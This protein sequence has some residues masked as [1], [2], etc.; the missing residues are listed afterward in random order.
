MKKTINSLDIN[1]KKKYIVIGF[2]DGIYFALEFARQNPK[3]IIE[4]ISLDGSWVSVKMC[5]NRLLNWKKR[6]NKHQ[7]IQSQ[8]HLDNI[9]KN[10][11]EKKEMSFIKL[12]MNHK[13]KEH[14]EKCI[15]YKYENIIKKHKFTLFRDFNSNTQKFFDLE[16]NNYSIIEN[17]ILKSLSKNYQIFWMIDGSHMFWT[18][19]MYK[20]Q[21][22]NYIKNI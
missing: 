3:N 7:T 8:K 22:Y 1:K 13:R 18:N 5:K 12:I 16:Y 21:L 9:L 6:N 10:I 20:N 17:N 19:E 11:I 14:T 15:K 4:I 2:S